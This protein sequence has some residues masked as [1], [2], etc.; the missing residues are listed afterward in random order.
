MQFFFTGKNESV[1]EFFNEEFVFVQ[2]ILFLQLNASLAKYVL[3]RKENVPTFLL[4]V[5]F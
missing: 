2:R 1:V 3:C 4:K 5:D